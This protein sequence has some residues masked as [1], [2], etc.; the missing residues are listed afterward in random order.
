MTTFEIVSLTLQTATPVAWIVTI[1]L[2]VRRR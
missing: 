2:L 1:G